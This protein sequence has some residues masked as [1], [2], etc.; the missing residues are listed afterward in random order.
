MRIV[1]VRRISQIFFLVIF[2]WFCVTAT[3]GANWWQL[4]GWPINWIL[5]LDP[6]TALATALSTGTLYAN[7]TWAL[8]TI[9]LTLFLGR[10][11]CGFACPLGA[12]NQF[13]GWLYWRHLKV[14]E[15]VEANRP[16]RLQSFKYYLLAFLLA[17]ALM[18]SVQTGVFDPLPLVHRSVNLALV[19]LADPGVL[20]DEPRAYASVWLLGAVFLTVVGLNLVLPRFFCRFLC[21][22]GALFGLLT[23]FIPSCSLLTTNDPIEAGSRGDHFS[24]V[25]QGD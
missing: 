11:F 17:L 1:T 4:R 20:S 12:I 24:I 25:F 21:P 5:E 15:K 19:P 9:L 7:L 18:G 22:L 3:L 8:V 14:S 10:F 2:L 13:T 16:R 23:R 6:L